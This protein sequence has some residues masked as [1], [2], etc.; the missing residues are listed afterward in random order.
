M[1]NALADMTMTNFDDGSD[2]TEI[3]GYVPLLARLT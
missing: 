3:D 1:Q 2:N